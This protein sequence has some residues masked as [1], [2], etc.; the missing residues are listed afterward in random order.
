M[1]KSVNS[2]V[3]IFLSKGLSVAN[4]GDKLTSI[5]QGLSLL[6]IN[7]SKPKSSKQL[8]LDGTINDVAAKTTFSIDKIVF[9]IISSIFAKI[10][11]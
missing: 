7:I 1:N 4:E 10:G 11:S 5:N 8:F 3:L 2:P 9:M 6:S